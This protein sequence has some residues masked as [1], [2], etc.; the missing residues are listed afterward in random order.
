MYLANNLQPRAPRT[1][2]SQFDRGGATI[3]A[4]Q[5][6]SV[7]HAL[8]S[9]R[10]SAENMSSVSRFAW[11]TLYFN[12]GV[13]LWGSFVRATGSGAGCGNK[14][15]GCGGVLGASAK[16]QTII[17]FTHRMTSAIA[18]LMVISLSLWCWR[19]TSKRDWARYSA[20]L[21]TI[22]LANEALL[23]AALVLLGHVARDQ[24]AGRNIFL[25]LH[26]GNTLLLLATQ[27]ECCSCWFGR[28]N[29]HWHDWYNG[30]PRRYPL[31]CSIT[32]RITIARLCFQYAWYFALS[33]AP[34]RASTDCWS[35]CD[36]GSAEELVAEKARV[37]H[38][39]GSYRPSD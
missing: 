12:V 31:P 11:A 32:P 14:W 9:M 33:P 36:L 34:S 16:T 15:P 10:S 8:C 24:S 17:E 37:A 4:L 18:L 1:R 29:G 7:Q 21:A 3:S 6:T 20:M 25:C 26:F 13:M 22:F 30:S 23:G 39:D 38:L 5:P 27:G 35:L 28:S 19:V 2:S